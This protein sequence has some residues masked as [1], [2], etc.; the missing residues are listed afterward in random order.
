MVFS[1][2]WYFVFL[3]AVLLAL[4]P[5]A[6]VDARKRVL[7]VASCLFYAAWDWR[8]L[9]LL[10]LISVV[11]YLAA[12][13]ID[14]AEEP[15]IRRRWLLASLVANLGVLGGFKYANFFIDNLNGPLG[16]AGRTLPHLE[17]LLPAGISFY[18]FKAMSYV[19]DVYRREL[20]PVRRYWDYV[21]FITF[22]PELIAGPIV[23]ASVLLPQLDRAIGATP[24]RLASGINIFLQGFT[25]KILADRLGR[26]VDPVFADPAYFDGATAWAAVLAYSLQIFCDFSGYSDMAIGT[27]RMIGYDLP[28]NFAMPYLSA[29]IAEFWGRWHITLSSWLRDYLYIPLGGNRRGPGRTTV[30][31]LVTMLLGGL[32]HGASWNFVAWGGLH[33]LALGAHRRWGL[34]GRL[35]RPLGVGLTFLFVSLAWIP[36]R[37]E[38]FADTWTIFQSLVLLPEGIRWIAPDLAVIVA[39]CV[40]GHAFGATLE[41]GSP[42]LGRALAAV[43]ARV[44]PDPIRGTYLQLGFV[45]LTPAWLMTVWVLLLVLLALTRVSPF[46]YFQF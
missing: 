46:I 44:V 14:R 2:P 17:I 15:A 42:R 13:R 7:A 29:N 18:T 31:L 27:G 25:K 40:A 26:M 41:S 34:A 30:N 3:A 37:A 5:P 21:T 4:A 38:T 10:L 43:G 39:L 9:G 28:R 20:A 35:P 24:E 12:D 45:G 22:F 36:F 6:S 23:R 33:G 8:Y 19:I 1:N 32:W 16:L 11:D